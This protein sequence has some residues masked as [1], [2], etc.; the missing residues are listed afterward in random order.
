LLLRAPRAADRSRC[1]I[2]D[3]RSPR[4]PSIARTTPATRTII[5]VRVVD[6]PGDAVDPI[7]V[8]RK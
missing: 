7:A 3:P 4:A 8:T 5:R 6:R 1:A 2:G